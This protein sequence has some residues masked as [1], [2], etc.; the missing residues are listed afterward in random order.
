MAVRPDNS[1]GYS[2]PAHYSLTIVHLDS[3]TTTA[4]VS[5]WGLRHHFALHFQGGIWNAVTAN[6]HTFAMRVRA[7]YLSLIADRNRCIPASGST[8][9]GSNLATVP[10]ESF[11]SACAQAICLSGGPMMSLLKVCRRKRLHSPRSSPAAREAVSALHST[12]PRTK[13]FRYLND[14][15]NRARLRLA[16]TSLSSGFLGRIVRMGM[17]SSCLPL[18]KGGVAQPPIEPSTACSR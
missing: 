8:S 6:F 12:G 18:A 1:A 17:R 3:E 11:A 9:H 14:R 13:L 10:C 5:R 16:A 4:G 2:M 15:S 7:A